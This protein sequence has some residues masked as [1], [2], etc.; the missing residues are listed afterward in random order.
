MADEKKPEIGLSALAGE[1]AALDPSRPVC[2][3]CLQ[4]PG[5]VDKFLPDDKKAE[6]WWSKKAVSKDMRPCCRFWFTLKPFKPLVVG[7][8][9][10]FVMFVKDTSAGHAVWLGKQQSRHSRI[11]WSVGQ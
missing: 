6:L 5:N 2:S 3:S 1:R 8:R 7:R 9:L 11:G 4:Q 10:A